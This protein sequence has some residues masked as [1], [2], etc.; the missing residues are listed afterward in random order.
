MPSEPAVK[1]VAAFVDGQNLFYAA[2]DA[3]GYDY[4]NYDVLPLAKTVCCAKG[5]TLT[6]IRFYTGIPAPKHDPQK[7]HFWSEKLAA[8]GRKEICVYKRFLRYRRKVVNLHDGTE[9]ILKVGQEKGIDIRIALDVIRLAHRKEY[10]VA[11]LF[12]Q[13]QDFSEVADE[14]RA[15]AREQNRWIKIACAF[16]FSPATVNTRGIDR[17]DWIKIDRATYDACLDHRDYRPKSNR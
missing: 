12:S 9:E 4:P 5:W 14:I 8:M 6:D 15:I 1:R 13:D 11:L 16:P 7:Y 17:T 3:F 2:R 10:D